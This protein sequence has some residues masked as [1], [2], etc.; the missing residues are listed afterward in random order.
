VKVATVL[1][2]AVSFEFPPLFEAA[3]VAAPVAIKGL[4]RRSHGKHQTERDR[5]GARELLHRALPIGIPTYETTLLSRHSDGT[6]TLVPPRA[7]QWKRREAQAGFP[8]RR[9]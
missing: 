8:A 4:A 6:E 1:E 7:S 9:E 5:H 2:S 3:I